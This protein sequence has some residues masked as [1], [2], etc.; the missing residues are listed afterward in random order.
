MNRTGHCSKQGRKLRRAT[1]T[2]CA[3]P[4]RARA[5]RFVD[6][7]AM[8]IAFEL[9]AS[10]SGEPLAALT[11]RRRRGLPRRRPSQ[12]RK[13]ALYLASTVLD[14]SVSRLARASRTTVQNV[15]LWLHQIEDARDN[16]DY[17]AFVARLETA[18]KR[19]ARTP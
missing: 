12:A 2:A 1:Q 17:D 14:I 19:Q 6:R 11:R 9:M 18:L 7:A 5:E 10:H 16:P 15:S 3:S 4:T 13:L 8:L